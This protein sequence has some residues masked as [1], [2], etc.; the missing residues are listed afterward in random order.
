VKRD[1]VLLFLSDAARLYLTRK[2]HRLG[3]SGSAL[4]DDSQFFA[5]ALF[6]P[7]L[8]ESLPRQSSLISGAPLF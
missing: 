8:P 5:T 7:N 1:A 3:L 6:Y 2:T 4:S